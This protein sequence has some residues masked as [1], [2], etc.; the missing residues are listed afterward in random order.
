MQWL[1]FGHNDQVHTED[2]PLP[3]RFPRRNANMY[4][5][6]ESGRSALLSVGA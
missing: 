2:V 4:A 5:R 3:L 1:F 6:H